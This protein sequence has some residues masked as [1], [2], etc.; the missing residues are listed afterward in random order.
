MYENIRVLERCDCVAGIGR[1]ERQILVDIAQLQYLSV[2]GNDGESSVESHVACLVSAERALLNL[3]AEFL[4][5]HYLRA[6]LHSVADHN[7]QFVALICPV[8]LRVCRV[9]ICIDGGAAC[10]LVEFQIAGVK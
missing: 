10:V 9:G 1:I 4:D 3:F 5:R 7:L 8:V 2:A 6:G